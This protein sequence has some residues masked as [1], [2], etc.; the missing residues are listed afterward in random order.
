VLPLPPDNTVRPLPE[1]ELDFTYQ[2]GH[3]P[4]GQHQDKTASAV[5]ATHRPTGIRVLINGRD[6]HRNKREA[7]RILTARVQEHLT[8]QRDAAFDRL[9]RE[10]L[11][12][13][14]RGRSHR[15][16]PRPCESRT[17]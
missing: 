8:R 3:G 11:G 15:W 9:R 2:C 14:R 17:G 10:Q 7:V 6:Q 12:D 5:Q 4:G 13:A 1:S 16:R